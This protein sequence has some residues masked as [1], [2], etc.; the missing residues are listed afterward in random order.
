MAAQIQLNEKNFDEIEQRILG[1][2]MNMS[3]SMLESFKFRMIYGMKITP[4]QNQQTLNSLQDFRSKNWD[5]S[6]SREQAYQKYLSK[7]I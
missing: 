3:K 7:S 6:E 1:Q 5:K 4:K 2:I